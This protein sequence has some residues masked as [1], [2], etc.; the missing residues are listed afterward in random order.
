VRSEFSLKYDD[1]CRLGNVEKETYPG[2][3]AAGKIQAPVSAARTLQPRLNE[4]RFAFRATHAWTTVLLQVIKVFF[5]S[6]IT[7]RAFKNSPGARR[8]WPNALVTLRSGPQASCK[9]LHLSAAM[10][11][12]PAESLLL[13]RLSVHLTAVHGSVDRKV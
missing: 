2:A 7:W 11:T 4:R 3:A 13:K 1:Y 6:R 10:R 5:M 9:S 12:C 8:L